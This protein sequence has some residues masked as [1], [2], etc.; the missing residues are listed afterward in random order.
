M[1]RVLLTALLLF[2][3]PFL[4]YALY[5]AARGRKAAL[6]QGVMDKAPVRGLIVAG[7]VAAVAG[8]IGF[9]ILTQSGPSY[10]PPVGPRVGAEQP[11]APVK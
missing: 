5:V 7:I 1:V 9:A 8:L 11:A 2:A 3:L 4:V 6:Q 10:E